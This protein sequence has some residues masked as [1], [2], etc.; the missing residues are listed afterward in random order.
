MPDAAVRPE[1]PR[2]QGN[3]R[4]LG[5]GEGRR[6]RQRR[7]R[8]RPE[9]LQDQLLMYLTNEGITIINMS[10]D[11]GWLIECGYLF[12]ITELQS[13]YRKYYSVYK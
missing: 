9:A 4:R 13:K 8:Q 3:V 5:R 2:G 1:G 11:K 10:H 6:R 7:R 12:M